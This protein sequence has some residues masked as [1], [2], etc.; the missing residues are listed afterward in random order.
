MDREKKEKGSV[1]IEASIVFPVMFLV[2]FFMIFAGNA[3]YQKCRVNAI[4]NKLTIYGAAHCADPMLGCFEGNE[5]KIP[6]TKEVKIYPYR[7]LIGGMEDIENSIED[8]IN[9]EVKKL[10]SGLFS[11]MK[12]EHVKIKTDFKNR[13]IYSNFS[14]EIEY[15]ITIPIRLLGMSDYIVMQEVS[16]LD[17]PVP[18]TMEFIRNTDMAEDIVERFLNETPKEKIAELIDKA[19]E[20]FNKG[21]N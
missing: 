6:S 19:K 20:W 9:D 15:K 8:S 5:N 10:N 14:T 21:G 13:F 7:F 11:G 17:M 2:I 4:V 1:I 16:I 18:D 12:A 3:Y